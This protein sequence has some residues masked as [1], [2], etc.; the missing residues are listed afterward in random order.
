MGDTR[1]I[2]GKRKGHND[3]TNDNL[4]TTSH[5]PPIPRWNEVSWPYQTV[6]DNLAIYHQLLANLFGIWCVGR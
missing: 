4:T 1:Q 3:S 2:E 6:N 5:K